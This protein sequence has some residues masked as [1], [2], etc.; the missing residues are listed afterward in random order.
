M[1]GYNVNEKMREAE[2]RMVEKIEREKS[3]IQENTVGEFFVEI[4]LDFPG[5]LGQIYDNSGTWQW[6]SAAYGTTTYWYQA[7]PCVSGDV[8]RLTKNGYGNMRVAFLTELPDNTETGWKTINGNNANA[9]FRFAGTVGLQVYDKDVELTAPDNAACLF[10][11][12]GFTSGGTASSP[13]THLWYRPYKLEK[14]VSIKE[15]MA[16]MG[17]ERDILDQYPDSELLP[18]LRQLAANNQE[19]SSNKKRSFGCVMFGHITDCHGGDRI[20]SGTN[21]T[22]VVPDIYSWERFI[23][24]MQHLKQNNE[25]GTGLG[26]VHYIDEIVDTGDI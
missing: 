1:T 23:R 3:D 16:A 7:V 22:P 15:Y 21:I 17:S 14:K 25:T 4:G 12:M 18:L 19:N 9:N 24:L 6:R 10:I 13:N 5:E 20:G 2:Q 26:V 11:Y 8:F